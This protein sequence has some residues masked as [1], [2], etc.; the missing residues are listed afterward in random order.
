MT[1][2]APL[3][4]A[5]PSP[6]LRLLVLRELLGRPGDD[7]EVGELLALREADPLV[8]ELLALETPSGPVGT[9]ARRVLPFA[10]DAGHLL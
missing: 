8:R 1:T 5:D 7:A 4:L 3:L 10:G 9:L 6:N 2:L